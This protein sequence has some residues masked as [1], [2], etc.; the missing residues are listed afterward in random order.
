MNTAYTI[1]VLDKDVHL[2]MAKERKL[3]TGN[4]TEWSGQGSDDV[5]A[6]CDDSTRLWVVTCVC[7]TQELGKFYGDFR[8]KLSTLRPLRPVT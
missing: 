8:K 5:I 4:M 1:K 2:Y 7:W 3:K 6:Q